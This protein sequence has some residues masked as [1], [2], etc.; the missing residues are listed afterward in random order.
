M[1]RAP[2][3]VQLQEDE[4]KENEELNAG[5]YDGEGV[6]DEFGLNDEMVEGG[7]IK[8]KRCEPSVTSRSLDMKDSSS[9]KENDDDDV[10]GE[11]VRLEMSFGLI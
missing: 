4:L 6:L 9:E 10:E 7:V 3:D 5:I 2:D 11:S 1:T 8:R